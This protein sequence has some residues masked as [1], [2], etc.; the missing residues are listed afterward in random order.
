MTAMNMKQLAVLAG[1]DVSTVS[2]AL[3][4]DSSRVA[5][6]TIERIQRLAREAGYVPD[7]VAS[8]LRSGRSRLIGVV[9]PVLSDIVMAILA[10]AIEEAFRELGYLSA[11]IATHGDAGVRSAAIDHL[12]GHK[13]AGFVLCDTEVGCAIPSQLE[14]EPIPFVYAM[15]RSDSAVS[16][17][18]DDYRGGALVGEHFAAMGHQ[19]V[20]VVPGPAAASTSLDRVTGFTEAVMDHPHMKLMAGTAVG[21]FGV[22]DGHR[23]ALQM[24]DSANTTPTA[25]FCA[26]DHAAIGA[27]RALADRGLRVGRDVA[28][29]GYND[30]PQAAYLETPLSSVRTDLESMGRSAAQCLVSLMEGRDAHSLALEPTLIVRASSEKVRG[31]VDQPPTSRKDAI[32]STKSSQLSAR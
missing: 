22:D 14:T 16:V 18:A 1:V 11:V 6:A 5:T 31:R 7:P 19:H 25:I 20:A 2:R 13:V 15:R 27:G 9:V 29:V 10:T 28:L 17:T 12:L 21:G 32:Q 30:I 26:N 23:Y 24:L 4:G 3:R 8:S